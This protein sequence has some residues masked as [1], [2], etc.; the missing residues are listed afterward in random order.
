MNGI[1]GPLQDYLILVVTIVIAFIVAKL[2]VRL[3][4]KAVKKLQSSGRFTPDLAEFV[5]TILRAA[6]WL[7]LGLFVLTQILLIFGLQDILMQS[8]SSFLAENAARIGVMILIAVVGYVA[9]RILGIVFAEYKRR[10]KLQP[11]TVDLL[12]SLTRYLV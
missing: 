8:V 12:Y 4:V 7:A 6:V 1:L 5:G 10:T 11:I 3:V 2:L 9:I